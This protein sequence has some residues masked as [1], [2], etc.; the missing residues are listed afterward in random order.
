MLLVDFS[1]LAGILSRRVK[2]NLGMP[3]EAVLT[4]RKKVIVRLNSFSFDKNKFYVT[5]CYVKS[6][7]PIRRYLVA[8]K[9]VVTVSVHRVVG[10]SGVL[11]HRFLKGLD[12]IFFFKFRVKPCTQPCSYV[13]F[14]N[15][16]ILA[17]IYVLVFWFGINETAMEQK[18]SHSYLLPII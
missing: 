13:F 17:S 4:E 15:H 5:R 8:R 1:P 16:G 2:I 9:S 6:L 18:A 14:F 12:P 3:E 11:C 7:V 10:S